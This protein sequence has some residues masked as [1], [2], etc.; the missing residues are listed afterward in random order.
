MEP[1]ALV[2]RALMLRRLAEQNN[3][4]PLV[5]DGYRRLADELERRAIAASGVA[6]P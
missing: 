4:S 6:A 1:A 3:S 5:R 2:Q